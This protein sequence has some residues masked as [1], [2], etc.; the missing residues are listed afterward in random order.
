MNLVDKIKH[1]GLKDIKQF[2]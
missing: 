2:P 1:K